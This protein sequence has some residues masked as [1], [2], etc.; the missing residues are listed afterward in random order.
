MG[1]SAAAILARR[2]LE[3][4]TQPDVLYNL[5]GGTEAW[6]KAGEPVEN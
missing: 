6:N 3:H 5:E 1:L 4:Q 2:C